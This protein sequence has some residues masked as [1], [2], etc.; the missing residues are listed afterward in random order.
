MNIDFEKDIIEWS[1]QTIS[2]LGFYPSGEN[3]TRSRLAQ[4]FGILRNMIPPTPRKIK[5]AKGFAY[6]E[7]HAKGYKQI[8]SEIEKGI[9]LTPRGSRK[10]TKEDAY[11]DPMLL[12]WNIYHLHLGKEVIRSGKNKGLIQ[13]HKEI[14]FVFFENETAYIIG[15]FDHSSWT[16]QEVLEIIF[17]NWPQL[18]ER[19]KIERAIALSRDVTEAGR[20]SLR[21]AQINSPIKIGNNVYMGP[22]GGMTTSG[23]GAN[24]IEK[25]LIVLSAVD[26]LKDYIKKNEQYIQRT[27]GVKVDLLNFD[28][29][30]FILSRTFS[31]YDRKNK[32]RLFIPSV[33]PVGSLV[34][35]AQASIIEPIPKNYSYHNPSSFSDLLVEKVTSS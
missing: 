3:D 2:R 26:G 16:K 25:V 11:N 13:G 21:N 23:S 15:V 9:D 28:V 14:L 1:N 5:I 18:I 19:W 8:L 33:D 34:H 29:S 7:A 4:V 12:D 24:E 6:P 27:V 20:Q 22:G 31:V 17:K 32:L 10:Q 35:P 30:R